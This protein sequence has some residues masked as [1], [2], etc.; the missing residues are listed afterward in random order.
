VSR[1][2]SEKLRGTLA[3]CAPSAIVPKVC[4]FDL[5]NLHRPC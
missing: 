5:Q 4:P 3:G 1:A 2:T